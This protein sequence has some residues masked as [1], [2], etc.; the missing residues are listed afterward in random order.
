MLTDDARTFLF[1]LL[2]TPSPSG[3]EEAGQRQWA[4]HLRPVA[5]EVAIDAYGSAW[6]KL[7]G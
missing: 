2:R 3:F 4:A 5:D 7:M 6:A 1:N